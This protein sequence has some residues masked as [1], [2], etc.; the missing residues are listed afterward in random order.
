MSLSTLAACCAVGLLSHPFNSFTILSWNQPASFVA[1][2][3]RRKIESVLEFFQKVL[4]QNDSYNTR[5]YYWFHASMRAVGV[6]MLYRGLMM[7]SC[8][9]AFSLSPFVPSWIPSGFRFIRSKIVSLTGSRRTAETASPSSSS[10]SLGA[11]AA[12]STTH[13]N[14][15]AQQEVADSTLRNPLSAQYYS[16]NQPERILGYTVSYSA[17]MVVRATFRAVTSGIATLLATPL[18]IVLIIF[19]ADIS[20][21]YPDLKR[22]WMGLKASCVCDWDRDNP[23][24]KPGDNPWLLKKRPHLVRMIWNKLTKLDVLDRAVLPFVK[25]AM[26]HSLVSSGIQ[27]IEGWLQMRRKIHDIAGKDSGNN[28]NEERKVEESTTSTTTTLQKAKNVLSVL[29]RATRI[30]LVAAIAHGLV[31]FSMSQV[32]STAVQNFC[33]MTDYA[34]PYQAAGGLCSVADPLVLR[35][36]KISLF[37]GISDGVCWGL[38]TTL[39]T[40]WR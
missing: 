22:A 34:Q 32:L 35:V 11:A 30:F 6:G 36:P 17:G 8:T 40:L 28:D 15:T 24:Y 10:T 31:S 26:T 9:G 19:V 29:A 2:F 38:I 12:T 14:E 3:A 7:W 20:N 1:A 5:D 23:H 16:T 21:G 39:V 13:N 33:R 18:Q 25:Y 37:F 27:F 4:P